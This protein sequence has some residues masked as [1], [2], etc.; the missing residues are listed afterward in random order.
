MILNIPGVPTVQLN[1]ISLQDGPYSIPRNKSSISKGGTGQV[2]VFTC[3]SRHAIIFHPQ[4]K[5]KAAYKME[6]LRTR[7]GLKP[8]YFLQHGVI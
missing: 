7:C 2:V 4:V 1:L 6:G 3:Q 5:S 8:H